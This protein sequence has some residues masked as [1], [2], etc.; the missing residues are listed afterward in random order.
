M[1]GTGFSG[2]VLARQL[3]EHLPDCEIDIIDSRDH[4]GGNCHTERD[5]KT[6]IM[7][8]KYGAHIFHTNRKDVW[9]YVNKFASFGNYKHRVIANTNRGIFSLPINLLTINQLFQKKMSPEEAKIFVRNLGDHTIHEPQ[10]FEEQALKFVGKEIYETFF[11]GYTKKQWGCEP[12]ELPASVLK[13][14]PVRFDYNDNY[15]ND[16][17][18]GIPVNGYT[19]LI[20]N[21][22]NHSRI[23]I[24]LNRPFI[25]ESDSS[26]YNH[27]FYAGPIDGYYNFSEG[28]LSYRTIYFERIDAIGDF[29]GNSVINYTSMNE[30]FT[31]LCEHKHFAPWE[32]FETSVVYKEFSK[33]T[34]ESDIPF[35]PKHLVIDK[36][37][38]SK[39][40]AIAM[41][42][43]NISFIGRLGTYRYLDMHHVVEESLDFARTVI[44]CIRSKSCIPSFSV[45]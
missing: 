14:L 39:Y 28:R 22:I 5:A 2:A 16:P 4:I 6:G 1:V 8:H 12:K 31:R 20:A 29:Q 9:D 19:D 7:L 40:N 33:E 41:A 24:H 38:F 30:N 36:E 32:S 15:F 26:K 18:Q 35:Y 45:K 13:R 21:I 10:N 23:H 37:I 42:E 25:K 43:E 27:I 34:G 44:E 3:V 17:Y 11:Y